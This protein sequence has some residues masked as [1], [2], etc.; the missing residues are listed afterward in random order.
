MRRLRGELRTDPKKRSWY[1]NAYSSEMS[2][3]ANSSSQIKVYEDSFVFTQDITAIAMTKT[4]LG[5]STKDVIGMLPFPKFDMCYHDDL[6]PLL[7][8]VAT[9]SNK[10]QSYP[11]RLLDPRR[12]RHKP[13]NSELEEGLMQYHPILPDNP[14]LVLSHSY[15]V[16]HTQRI[17]IAPSLLESTSL[18]F[19][20]GLDMFL[21]RTSPSGTFD[22]LSEGFNK[23][24]LVLTVVGLGL[25][26]LVTRPIVREKRLNSKWFF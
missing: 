16:A 13:T 1:L 23:K 9:R 15:D 2:S 17:T 19:C 10:I 11:H 22:L 4:K 26:I 5:I 7:L 20:E 14:K 6:T 8:Q 3:F 12:P 25:G 24:Q 18:V 21:T